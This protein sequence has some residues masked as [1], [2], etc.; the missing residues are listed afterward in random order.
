MMESFHEKEK[1][2]EKSN[3]AFFM[4]SEKKQ[5]DKIERIQKIE[6]IIKDNLEEIESFLEE[7]E[8]KLSQ[9]KYFEIYAKLNDLVSAAEKLRNTHL[10][11][12]LRKQ[13]ELLEKIKFEKQK[14][15]LE[16]VKEWKYFK[17]RNN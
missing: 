2:E 11:S 16:K 3:V 10:L 5:L 15:G 12:R 9:D 4:R 1:G 13:S 7:G 8:E 6:K 14:A 17:K